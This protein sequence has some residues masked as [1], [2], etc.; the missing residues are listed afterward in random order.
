MDFI[1]DKHREIVEGLNKIVVAS[2]VPME[3]NLYYMHHQNLSANQTVAAQFAHK[4][5]QLAALAKHKVNV[6]EIGF[7]AGHSAALMLYS[8]P[9]LRYRGIDIGWHK[10]TVPCAQ[11][12]AK[13]FPGRV[14][15]TIGDSRSA[16]P[17]S[18]D[19]YADCDLIHIDG[20]H[21]LE[22]FRIDLVHAL[23]LPCT[24]PDRH[25]LIDDTEDPHNPAI[26]PELQ[27][28]IDGG[29]VAIDTLGGVMADRGN[30]LLVKPLR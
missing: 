8:N 12:L 21:S 5:R 28:W 20:G 14:E 4:R 23:T 24:N 19:K 11:F 26:S 6:M 22:L 25:L 2:G 13:V 16:Y 17:Y 15:L 18:F 1:D 9:D 27:K 7:N 29:Y 10:Y 30:H 3:G